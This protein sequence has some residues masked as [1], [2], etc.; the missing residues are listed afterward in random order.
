MGFLPARGTD[1]IFA[2][3]AEEWGFAGATAVLALYAYL[4]IGAATIARRT[5]DPFGRLLAVGVMTLV[6]TQALINTAMTVRLAPVTGLPLPFVSLGGSSLVANF[7]ALGILLN[8]GARPTAVLSRE[9][10]Q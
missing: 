6:A 9:D 1:F 7:I 10:F 5:R 3:V 8:V 2:S 4:L